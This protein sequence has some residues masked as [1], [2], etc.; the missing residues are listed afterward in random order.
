MAV[1]EK[2]EFVTRPL[3][4]VEAGQNNNKN[5]QPDSII[6]TSSHSLA[7]KRVKSLASPDLRNRQ[8]NRVFIFTEKKSRSE[9]ENTTYLQT[10]CMFSLEAIARKILPSKRVIVPSL[11]PHVFGLVALPQ[12]ADSFHL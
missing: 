11:V 12:S 6:P 1:E 10:Y 9:Q 8:V 7:G 4:V 3:I 2:R 5:E